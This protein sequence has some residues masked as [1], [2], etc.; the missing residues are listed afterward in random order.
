MDRK[1]K[2]WKVHLIG[3]NAW[4]YWKD[5]FIKIYRFDNLGCIY[6]PKFSNFE[7]AYRIFSPGGA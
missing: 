2:S 7:G 3:I 5:N 4:H 6:F 1:K